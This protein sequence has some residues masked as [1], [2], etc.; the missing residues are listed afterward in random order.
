MAPASNACAAERELPADPLLRAAVF[1]FPFWHL[2]PTLG[3][4]CLSGSRVAAQLSFAALH[5][6]AAGAD[7]PAEHLCR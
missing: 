7:F 5:P 2:N 3:R 6:A 4:E 1:F